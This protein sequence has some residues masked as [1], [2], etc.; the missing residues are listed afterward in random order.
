MDNDQCVLI[1]AA[2]GSKVGQ[3]KNKLKEL[4]EIFGGTRV[5]KNLLRIESGNNGYR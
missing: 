4:L 5:Y 3:A 2:F 1:G